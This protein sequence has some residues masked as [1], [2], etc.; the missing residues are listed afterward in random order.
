[1]FFDRMDSIAAG[2]RPENRTLPDQRGETAA[3]G[4]EA[5]RR[6]V[7]RA[8][9]GSDGGRSPGGERLE[10]FGEDGRPDRFDQSD[11]HGGTFVADQG[12]GGQVGLRRDLAKL[13]FL[14][15]LRMGVRIGLW[16]GLPMVLRPGLRILRRRFVA[17]GR[18]LEAQNP[19]QV[20]EKAAQQQPAGP[21]REMS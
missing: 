3:T 11:G 5:F 9:I 17:M 7:R 2:M 8:G 10:A 19:E 20:Y 12:V 21:H 6:G 14:M 15:G 18:S 1:M 16:K 13:A 4:A